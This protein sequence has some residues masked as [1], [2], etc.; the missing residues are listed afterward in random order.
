[1]M[2]LSGFDVAAQAGI[3]SL[4]KMVCVGGVLPPRTP[5]SR[6]SLPMLSSYVSSLWSGDQTVEAEEEI[7]NWQYLQLAETGLESV[8]T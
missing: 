5:F 2:T 7:V 1:M 6:F 4:G 3:R 8:S